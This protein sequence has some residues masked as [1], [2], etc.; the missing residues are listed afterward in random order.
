MPFLGSGVR[1]AVARF[2]RCSARLLVISAFCGA[3]VV[4][5]LVVAAPASAWPYTDCSNQ[6]WNSPG[7]GHYSPVVTKAYDACSDLNLQVTGSAYFTGC[8]YGH[9]CAGSAVWCEPSIDFNV[10]WPN[11]TDG[12]PARVYDN[13]SNGE[14]TRLVF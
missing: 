4:S 6:V 8:W 2:R 11:F 10:L 1:S 3:A 9:Y 13:S 7:Y 12:Q 14:A 5:F